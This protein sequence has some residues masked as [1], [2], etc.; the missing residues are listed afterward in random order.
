MRFVDPDESGMRL[1]FLPQAVGT[2]SCRTVEDEIILMLSGLGVKCLFVPKSVISF[3]HRCRA[4]GDETFHLGRMQNTSKRLRGPVGKRFVLSVRA[5]GLYVQSD[6]C[7]KCKPLSI[8]L[9]APGKLCSF[10]CPLAFPQLETEL[11]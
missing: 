1:F 4:V 8:F 11:Q 2:F 5:R 6:L 7:A 10:P 9:H 3:L